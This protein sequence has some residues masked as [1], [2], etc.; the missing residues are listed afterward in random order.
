MEG[1]SGETSDDDGS[2]GFD[3][4]ENVFDRDGLQLLQSSDRFLL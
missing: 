2:H 1:D 3:I 4:G